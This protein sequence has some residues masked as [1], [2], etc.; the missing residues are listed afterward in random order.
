LELAAHRAAQRPVQPIPGCSWAIFRR[1]ASDGSPVTAV[2][3]HVS[4]YLGVNNQA[5][6]RGSQGPQELNP[7]SARVGTR[8]PSRRPIPMKQKSR[9]PGFWSPLGGFRLPV[10]FGYPEASPSRDTPMHSVAYRGWRHDLR[11]VLML[12]EYV[13]CS[14]CGFHWRSAT[15]FSVHRRASSFPA[16]P[17]WPEPA[18]FTAAVTNPQLCQR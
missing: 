6:T 16:R 8:P 11:L 7:Y 17:R 3:S 4:R 5:C 13:M 12:G 1:A 2:I 14:V 18:T 15:V 9:L 10:S